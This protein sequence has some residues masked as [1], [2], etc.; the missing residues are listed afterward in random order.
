[1]TVISECKVKGVF[2]ALKNKEVITVN[3]E[4][5]IMP[6]YF[7]FNLEYCEYFDELTFEQAGQAIKAICDYVRDKPIDISELDSGTKIVVKTVRQDID[8]A[9]RKYHAQC[10]NGKKGG[11]PKGNKN[12]AKAKKKYPSFN[13]VSGNLAWKLSEFIYPE[14]AKDGFDINSYLTKSQ[15]ADIAVCYELLYMDSFDDYN[16]EYPT[17]KEYVFNE[18]ASK[19]CSEMKAQAIYEYDSSKHDN[20]SFTECFADYKAKALEILKLC[21]VKEMGKFSDMC[22]AIFYEDYSESKLKEKFTDSELALIHEERAKN[23][24][25]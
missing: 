15:I 16:F 19:L 12:A 2:K 18:S 17:I 7:Y 9:F 10:E 6:K 14:T 13:E 5:K 21:P 20:K 23:N 24:P 22:D 8:K 11:A 25:K 4:E 1:M 3:N